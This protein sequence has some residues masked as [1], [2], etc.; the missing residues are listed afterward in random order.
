MSILYVYKCVWVCVYIVRI[1]D[2]AQF[3]LVFASPWDIWT[4]SHTHASDDGEYMCKLLK[5]STVLLLLLLLVFSF[6]CSA[7]L[8][9]H[10]ALVQ[11]LRWY[12][13]SKI[14]QSEI[15]TRL[16]DIHFSCQI[17]TDGSSH[18]VQLP[19]SIYSIFKL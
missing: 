15:K 3:S 1:V 7:V 18:Q 2:V 10:N 19:N 9:V 11:T 8:T 6:C 5:N 16:Y 14:K 13:C 4:R 17:Q 12:E